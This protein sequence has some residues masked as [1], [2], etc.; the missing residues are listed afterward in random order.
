MK[1]PENQSLGAEV[2]EHFETY[3]QKAQNNAQLAREVTYPSLIVGCVVIVVVSFAS[4]VFRLCLR[5][6]E[7]LRRIRAWLTMRRYRRRRFKIKA[8]KPTEVEALMLSGCKKPECPVVAR[9]KKKAEVKGSPFPPSL[10]SPTFQSLDITSISFS[11][12]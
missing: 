10:L 8:K 1:V 9:L 6:S 5:R 11:N 4:F 12:R 7:A 3:D 2:C